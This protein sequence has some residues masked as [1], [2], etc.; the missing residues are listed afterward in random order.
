MK[1][2]MNSGDDGDGLS[3]ERELLI[4]IVEAIDPHVLCPV[5]VGVHY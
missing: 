2:K 5:G 4:A 3:T 1:M